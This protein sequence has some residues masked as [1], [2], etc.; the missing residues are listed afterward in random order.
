MPADMSITQ[1]RKLTNPGMTYLWEFYVPLLP[2]STTIV[3]GSD[4]FLRTHVKN[5]QIPGFT[6]EPIELGYGDGS[7]SIPGKHK[8]EPISFQ[9]EESD[10]GNATALLNDWHLMCVAK[11]SPVLGTL[12][13]GDAAA[14]KAAITASAKTVLNNID[15][16]IRA[17][18]R[19]R[20]GLDVYTA[21]A[22]LTLLTSRGDTY[23]RVKLIGCWPMSMPNV[24]LDYTTSETIK[25][26]VTLS[27]D[28]WEL[29]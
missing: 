17:S 9:I 10:E 26:D 12:S 5:V 20:I 13:V 4:E 23:R 21:D 15:N 29:Q 14:L 3:G 25:V 11:S 8:Y 28:Y 16:A 22:Y 27:Y 2:G 6:I 24:A 1:L 18:L 7:I 19:E